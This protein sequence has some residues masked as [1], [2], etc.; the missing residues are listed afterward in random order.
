MKCGSGVPTVMGNTAKMVVPRGV[1][2]QR[3]KAGAV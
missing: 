3:N 1:T 2:P